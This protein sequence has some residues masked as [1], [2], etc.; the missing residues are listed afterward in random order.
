MGRR[1][2]PAGHAR[3]HLRV[4]D[5]R[6]GDRRVGDQHQVR[7]QNDVFNPFK[8]TNFDCARNIEQQNVSVTIL[9]IRVNIESLINAVS[10]I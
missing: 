6:A 1:Q 9:C 4:R 8:L 10:P 3:R 2:P 5:V 7:V